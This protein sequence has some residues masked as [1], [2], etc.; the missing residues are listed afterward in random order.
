[1]DLLSF[2]IRVGLR[3]QCSFLLVN[4]NVWFKRKAVTRIKKIA[5]FQTNKQL[6]ICLC[7]YTSHFKPCFNVIPAAIYLSEICVRTEHG[8][9]VFAPS[10]VND[11]T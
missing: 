9:P 2:V 10:D 7:S 4:S 8:K 11:W 1:M 3:L 5:V 6:T